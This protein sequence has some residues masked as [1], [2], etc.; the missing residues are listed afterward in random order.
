[1]AVVEEF[2]T[3]VNKALE[4]RD[5]EKLWSEVD[6]PPLPLIERILSQVYAR[7][8]SP[9]VETLRRYEN[10]TDNVYGEMLPRFVSQIIKDTRLRHDQV[11]VDLGSGVGNV[12]LQT[13]L[14]VGCQSWGCEMMTNPCDL[15]DIQAVEF[16]ARC[17]LWGLVPGMVTLLRGDFLENKE[18]GDVLKRADVILVNNQA[19]NPDLNNK[20]TLKFLDLKEGAR[21]VSL[22]SFVPSGFR[23]Q[24]RNMHDPRNLLRV[25]RKE[26]GSRCV[27]WTD[28][29]GEYYVATKDSKRLEE[30]QKSLK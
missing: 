24:A 26:Y 6:R 23:M 14:E 3:V 29:G 7:T 19:F 27:S 15:A 5:I 11:F 10:G 8:V 18:I 30:F 25:S 13:A 2:N 28:N 22:K 16:Y 12:V 20:L 21:I 1:M 9:R 17:R 4:S